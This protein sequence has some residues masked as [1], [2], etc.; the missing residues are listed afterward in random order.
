MQVYRIDD[1][2]M[3]LEDVILHEGVEV[4][5]DCIEIAP[6][7]GLFKPKW[8]GEEWVEGATAE[9]ITELTSYV[10]E[11]SEVENISNYLLDVDMRLI[12]LELG[13]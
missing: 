13:M 9:Y 6:L 11:P 5:P 12:M 7:Q 3:F 8:T 1:N 2:G 10:P 4:P